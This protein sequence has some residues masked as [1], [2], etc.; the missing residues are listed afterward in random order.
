MTRLSRTALPTGVAAGSLLPATQPTGMVHLGA[1]AFFRGHTAPFT[2]DAVRATGDERWGITA[3]TQRS[4]AVVAQLRPQDGLFTVTE[5]GAGAAPLRLVSGVVGVLG[6]RTE[7][8]A[9]LALLA[10]PA[11]AVVTLTVTEKG[12]RVDPVGGGLDLADPEVRAD[13]AGRSPQTAVGQLVRGLQRRQRADAGPLTVVP[14]DNLPGNGALTRRLVQDFTAA[15]PAGEGD[16]LRTWLDVSVAFPSTMVDRIVPAT[17]AAD[18]AAV[19]A[20]LGR[21]DEAAVVAEPFRQW[22]LEDA[23]AADR[24]AWDAV[25]AQLVADV[26]PWE[27]AKLRLLNATHSLIAYLGARAGYRTIAESVTDEVIGA[28]AERLLREDALPSITVPDGL[29]GP[30]YC[31]AV[32]TRFANPALGHTTAKVGSDGSQKIGLRLLTTLRDGLGQGRTPRWA[33]LA[34][35]AWLWH[36]AHTPAADLDDPLADVLAALLPARRDAAAVVPALLRCAQV[37]PPALAA[38]PR[39]VELLT[40]W[41]RV[42]DSGPDA[43]RTEVLR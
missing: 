7:T 12:Y 2:E 28:A 26:A 20:G 39:V 17:T 25:G 24:P 11:T 21:R 22:V 40:D 34:V 42:L 37:F 5:R 36:V 27:A 8:D 19:E 9:V 33:G 1:G 35:A 31:T 32:L 14:C 43:L 10:A 30:A 41:Y 15:L 23:F 38:D 13:L 18:L 16:A 6:G 29:D 4:D 3:V